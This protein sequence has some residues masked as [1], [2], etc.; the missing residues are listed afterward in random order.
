MK[1]ETSL[2]VRFGETDLLGHVNNSYY[3]TYL[4][5]ARI[6]F[7][8]HLESEKSLRS[9]RFILA[10]IKCDFLEQAYFDQALTI[11]TQVGRIGNKSF[12]LVQPIID[13]KSGKQIAVGES[14]LVYFD[15]D[16]QQSKPIP[17]ALRGKLEQYTVLKEE[18][19]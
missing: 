19:K 5:Q 7:V 11:V 16:K 13:Q 9:W 3:F 14:T 2:V 1:H 12:E 17:T 6:A 10:S 18:E 8:K 4:E 15:F